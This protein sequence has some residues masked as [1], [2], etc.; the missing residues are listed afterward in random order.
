MA[1]CAW[2]A[3]NGITVDHA[4][5][6]RGLKPGAAD[7]EIIRAYLD[8]ESLLITADRV[9]HN[10]ILDMGL[11]SVVI[12]DGA[13]TNKPIRL[14]RPA[15]TT[16]TGASIPQDHQVAKTNNASAIP[17]YDRLIP[18]NRT[19]LKKLHV[20]RR[21]ICGYFDGLQNISSTS[22]A[23]SVRRVSGDVLIGA[24][25]RVRSTGGIRALDASELYLRSPPQADIWAQALVAILIELI[26]T[27]LNHR[28][29]EIGL[30]GIQ[31]GQIGDHAAIELL[32]VNFRKISYLTVTGGERIHKLRKK[33]DSLARADT[34]NEIKNAD[35]PQVMSFLAQYV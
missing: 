35:L 14:D 22:V 12:I 25:I 6:V 17:Y 3:S 23:L 10:R 2:L 1:A 28:P 11:R 24:Q 8:E 15:R 34:G 20:R 16:P 18:H 31:P 30:D 19:Q 7:G 33:L 29:V 5:S 27:N 4:V 9:F 32:S 21:R 26:V 13:I